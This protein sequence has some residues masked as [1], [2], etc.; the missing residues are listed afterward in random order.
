M[1][2]TATLDKDTD[3]WVM[4]S[5]SV[6]SSKWWPGDLGVL[7]SHALVFAQ[8][9]VDGNNYGVN[10]F[11][12]QIR[13]KNSH[14]PLPGI[15]VG[16]IGPKFGFEAKDNGYLLMNQVRIPR[17]NLLSRYFD[18]A[19]D[20]S[21]EVKGNPL[22]LYSIM[23]FTRLQVASSAILIMARATTIATRYALVRTQFVNKKDAEGKRVERQ[24]LDYQTHQ[25]RIISNLSTMFVMQ[26]TL[27]ELY[28]MYDKMIS[29]IQK[30][31]DFSLMAP[32][33][34]ILSGIKALFCHIGYEGTKT[35]R[36]L[37][38]AAGF[39]KSA[40]I[41]ACISGN[42]PYVTLEGDSVVM[43]LQTAR[44]LLK[45]GRQ[46]IVKQKPTQN[47]SLSYLND[48]PT[49]AQ[50]LGKK[51]SGTTLEFFL[52]NSNLV[53]LL[54]IAALM[55]VG[56]CMTLFADP[57]YKGY[58]NWEKFYQTFQMD[59]FRMAVGHSYFMA[60]MFGQSGLNHLGVSFDQN[61][62]QHLKRMHRIFCLHVLIN[63]ASTLAVGG[64]LS[65]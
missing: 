57:K 16:D 20:G 10:S 45:I 25:V 1:E 40:G 26:L 15:E 55:G 50:N 23:M 64:Y 44:S 34:T 6:S 28:K 58:S 14:R 8:T 11:L 38:G 24:L 37:C 47:K 48:L 46:V 36:E 30:K 52:D 62:H 59:L 56:H 51:C 22:V 12:V 27:Q 3:Q 39:I 53:E 41:G 4:H 63:H 9:I 5:P 17:N 49:L 33:H 2:T 13:D 18:V 7:G 54:R 65:E 61:G 42:S 31:Q 21:V 35:M 60:A 29:N 32:M 19:K 43:N